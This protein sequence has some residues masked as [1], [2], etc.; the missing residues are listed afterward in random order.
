MFWV[1]WR[2]LCARLAGGRR[3]SPLVSLV[4]SG[5]ILGYLVL[6]YFIFRAGFDYLYRFPLVGTLLSQRILYM[7]FAFFFLMLVFSNLIIGYST[8]FK[9]RETQWFL[10]LPLTHRDVYRWKFFESVAISSW[11]LLFLSAPMM[12]AYGHLHEVSPIFF[13][14]IS[15]IFIPFVILPALFG[16]WSIL[17]LV[18]VLA[19]PEAKRV[20]LLLAVGII[21]LIVF[22]IKPTTDVDATTTQEVLSFDQ[23]LRHTRLSI[24]PINALLRRR[25]KKK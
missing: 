14:Q 18:R 11:A 12:I 25:R 24:N 15:F 10:S 1:Q 3:Q 7:I 8:L 5:F 2:T 21:F 20:A 9:N 6:G 17:L 23:L 22:G 19:R 4:L 13:L 16:S